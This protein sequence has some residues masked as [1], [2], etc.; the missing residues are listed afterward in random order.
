M[1]LFLLFAGGWEEK[2]CGWTTL[3]LREFVLQEIQTLSH[4]SFVVQYQ[5]L[6]LLPQ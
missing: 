2:S 1:F 5:T 3:E 4:L 6:L